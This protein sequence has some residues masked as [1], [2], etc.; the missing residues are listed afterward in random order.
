[1][2]MLKK[3][4]HD[5]I[6]RRPKKVNPAEEDYYAE[7]RRHTANKA[8]RDIPI[9]P[10]H[11]TPHYE[12][13]RDYPADPATDTQRF[14]KVCREADAEAKKTGFD[15][16]VFKNREDNYFTWEKK[17][18]S[19]ANPMEALYTAL[20]PAT[21]GCAQC[22]MKIPASDRCCSIKCALKFAGRDI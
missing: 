16:V 13:R 10:P 19:P 14:E 3:E 12:G 22:G 9:A 15:I 20:A 11:P 7:Q 4:H 1:M 17:Y 8:K 5:E 21:H 6:V 2:G 18:I